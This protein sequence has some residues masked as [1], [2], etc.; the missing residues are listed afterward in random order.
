MTT[1]NTNM[2]TCVTNTGSPK[3]FNLQRKHFL[4]NDGHNLMFDIE[5][6]YLFNKTLPKELLL[7]LRLFLKKKSRLL[8]NF[9]VITRNGIIFDFSHALLFQTIMCNK[10]VRIFWLVADRLI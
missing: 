5:W 1:M 3:T 9:L 4:P 10:D 8:L 7:L 2:I 6:K